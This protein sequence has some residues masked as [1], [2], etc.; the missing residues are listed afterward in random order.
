MMQALLYFLLD[1]YHIAHEF[2]GPQ[3]SIVDNFRQIT[4]GLS[5]QLKRFDVFRILAKHFAN[6]TNIKLKK[7]APVWHH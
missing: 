3:N 5:L 4:F 1:L 7:K 2:N 6:K